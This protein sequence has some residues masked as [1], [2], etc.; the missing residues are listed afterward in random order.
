[1]ADQSIVN[2]AITKGHG[3]SNQGSYLGSGQNTSSK[4]AKYSWAQDRSSHT[5]TTQL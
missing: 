4:N 2:E 5:E 3:R 1:M